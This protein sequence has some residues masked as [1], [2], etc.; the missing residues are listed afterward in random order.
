MN[1][2]LPPLVLVAGGLSTRLGS[3]TK[4]VPKSMVVVAVSRLSLTKCAGWRRKV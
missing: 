3:I 1:E 4:T 2:P